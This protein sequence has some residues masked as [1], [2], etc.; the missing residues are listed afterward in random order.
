M[1]W[2]FIKRSEKGSYPKPMMDSVL[3]RWIRRGLST[4]IMMSVFL[5]GFYGGFAL[6]LRA[7]YLEG[8]FAWLYV[9]LGL[10]ASRRL[11]I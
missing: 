7:E 9:I 6:A 5:A 4:L 10:L 8:L 1:L 11:W 2:A 3:V